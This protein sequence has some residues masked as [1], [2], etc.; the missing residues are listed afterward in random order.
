MP[1]YFIC[2][3]NFW[4]LKFI[5]SASFSQDIFLYLLPNHRNTTEQMIARYYM[6][7]ILFHAFIF[8]FV[9]NVHVTN[10]ETGKYYTCDL[11]HQLS[12]FHGLMW[13]REG[14]GSEPE[15][16]TECFEMVYFCCGFIFARMHRIA[17]IV[18]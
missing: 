13:L 12:S 1:H 6:Y 7:C 9:N 16:F 8:D 4:R 11:Q 5:S 17:N 2:H 3:H 14:S 18:K 15:T 10:T